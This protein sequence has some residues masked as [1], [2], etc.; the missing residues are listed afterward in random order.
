MS[1]HAVNPQHVPRIGSPPH[2]LARYP[3]LVSRVSPPQYVVG[4]G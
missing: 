4:G 2:P 1:G 3:P